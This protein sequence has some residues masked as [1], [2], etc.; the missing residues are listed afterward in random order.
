MPNVSTWIVTFGMSAASRSCRS[1]ARITARPASWPAE[2]GFVDDGPQP[3]WLAPVQ[4]VL[5]AYPQLG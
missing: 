4:H 1:W 3:G 2:C 5:A